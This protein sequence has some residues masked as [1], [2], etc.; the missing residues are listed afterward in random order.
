VNL[1]EKMGAT[2][3]KVDEN[4]WPWHSRCCMQRRNGA[5]SFR[6]T[7]KEDRWATM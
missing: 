6:G 2:S 5:D 7:A 1:R 3:F 4:L